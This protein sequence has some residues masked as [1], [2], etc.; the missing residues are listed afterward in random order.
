M[1]TD[2]FLFLCSVYEGNALEFLA[3]KINKTK[4][5][6]RFGLPLVAVSGQGKFCE[7]DP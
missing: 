5:T 6:V 3:Y 7:S 2:G 4:L 1:P